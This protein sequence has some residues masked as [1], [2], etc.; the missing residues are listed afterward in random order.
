VAVD[1]SLGP[2]EGF[3]VGVTANRRAHEQAELLRHRGAEVIFGAVI[4]TEHAGADESVHAATTA[5]IAAVPQYVVVTTAIGLR[6]WFDA[7]QSLGLDAELH[8]VLRSAR[9][10]ARGPKAAA[11]AQTV[12]LDVWRA[13]DDE[14]MDGVRAV[15]ETVPLRDTPVAVS[16][17]GDDRRPL[18][19]FLGEK[20]ARVI[21]VQA[22][23][24]VRPDDDQPARML[25]RAV[26]EHR[27]HAVTFTS[28]PA[29]DRLF[30]FAA[31][32]DARS[33]LCDAFNTSALAACVGPVCAQAA[34]S[35]GIIDPVAP[36]VG[37]L[38]LMIRALSDRLRTTRRRA[39]VGAATLD[40]Q[41][42]AAI[43]DGARVHLSAR[44]AGVLHELLA[45]PGAVVSRAAARRCA[46]G[47]EA[48]EEH[49]VT[50]TVGRLRRK[51]GPAGAAI[52]AL[53]RRGYRFVVD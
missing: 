28:A 5:V 6:S 37:R 42:C 16:C 43:V 14:R 1:G 27:V 13:A 32:L 18:D 24:W 17:F 47:S 52:Q 46:W 11:A 23:R 50:A 15:L 51:L 35:A 44:E 41:G 22:Y 39:R 30:G 10:I 9:L 21:A 36:T 12:G 40:V 53:P 8:R 34:R 29:V 26:T 4:G 33:E 45:Q 48:V 19:Q 31:D 49:A 3:V 25:V 20:G 7:A 38:G 2:L